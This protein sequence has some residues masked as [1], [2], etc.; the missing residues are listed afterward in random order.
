VRTRVWI[1]V[2]LREERQHSVQY[3]WVHRRRGLQ[4]R[5]TY[6]PRSV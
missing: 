6:S 5:S 4:G 3:S 2:L 1:S